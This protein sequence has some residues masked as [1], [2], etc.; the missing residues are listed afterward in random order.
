MELNLTKEQYISL[1]KALTIASWVASSVD[2][3][4]FNSLCSELEDIEQTVLSVSDKFG[5]SSHIYFDPESKTHFPT[6]LIEGEIAA[7]LECYDDFVFWDELNHRLAR[8][9]FVEEY[10]LD[11]VEKMDPLNRMELEEEFIEKYSEEFTTH[12][13]E[14]LQINSK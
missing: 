9:D 11:K 4:E 2:E 13:V 1:V 14:R 10:G 3:E 12:G 7:F 6:Q 8:R 5:A